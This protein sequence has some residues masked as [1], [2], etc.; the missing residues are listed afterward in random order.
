MG[1]GHCFSDEETEA[2]SRGKDLLKVMSQDGNKIPDFQFL[3]LSLPERQQLPCPS[4]TLA[5]LL[6][7][8]VC[9]Q[10]WLST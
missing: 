5:P 1:D 4:A 6:S 2:Q 9:P 8:Q 7:L 10:Q 3:R